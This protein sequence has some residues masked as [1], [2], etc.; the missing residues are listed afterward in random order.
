MKLEDDLLR[1]EAAIPK[2]GTNAFYRNRATAAG[3]NFVIFTGYVH[4]WK[5]TEIDKSVFQNYK[6]HE[7]W[8]VMRGSKQI[9]EF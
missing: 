9:Y 7:L 2:T 1:D 6:I 3:R 8:T 5:V 4:P